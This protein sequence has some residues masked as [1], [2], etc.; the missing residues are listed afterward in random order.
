M[1]RRD[2]DDMEIEKDIVID[3]NVA[4]NEEKL[5][6]GRLGIYINNTKQ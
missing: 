1:P 6:M 2:I 3:I 4:A 5:I